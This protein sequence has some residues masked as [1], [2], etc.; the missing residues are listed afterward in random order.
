MLPGPVFNVELLISARRRHYYVIRLLYGLILLIL[1]WSNYRA[2]QGWGPRQRAE[3]STNELA[4]F[5]V[6]TFSSFASLQAGAILAL[7]PALVAGAVADERRRKTL[8]YLLASRLS[9]GEIVLGKLMARLLH[10]GVL[11]A[12]GL[13]VMSLLG[14][15]GGIDPNYVL[16]V[17]AA[18]TTTAFFLAAIS[19]LVSSVTKRPRD[20]ILVAYLLELCWLALVPVLHFWL[21]SDFPALNA[22]VGPVFDFLYATHPGSFLESLGPRPAGGPGPW[23]P[24]AWLCGLQIAY[25]LLAV[26]LAVW[27]LRPNFRAE[28]EG[29]RR[30]RLP[31]LLPRRGGWRLLPRPACGDDPILWKELVVGRIG[32]ITKVVAAFVGLCILAGLVYGVCWTAPDAFRD[33]AT[34]GYG[35]TGNGANRVNFN[36]YIRTTGVMLYI[37]AALGVAATAAGGVTGEKEGDTWT[38]LVTT[39]LTGREILVGKMIGALWAMRWV[40]A[41]MA[42]QWVVGLAAGAIHPFGLVAVAGMTAIFL[43]FAAALGASMSL[44]SRTTTRSLGWTIAI[45][46]FLN[47]G[48]LV[49]G[50]PLAFM[51]RFNSALVTL[52]CTPVA[53]WL[54]P[55]SYQDVGEWLG[56]TQGYGPFSG[57]NDGG[58]GLLFVACPLVYAAG[59]LLLALGSING[60]DRA[61]DRPDRTRQSRPPAPPKSAAKPRPLGTGP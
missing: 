60:F 27:R 47:G 59:T 38:S 9:G 34:Y 4:A 43:A 26:A 39:D 16:M 35:S 46:V 40:I 17:Y 36:M 7:T 14:L 1:L 25:G 37:L 24:L 56:S 3:Y 23:V 52:G 51:F 18:T 55:V 12:I 32:G 58:V 8:H 19:I 5:A 53:H 6:G 21:R 42:A 10:V 61:I 13:P 22:L 31:R 20:A 11:L 50:S 41:M 49:C 30:L 28:G 15:F 2:L 33:V 44:R 48:Y 45:L 54:G 57:R 29:R